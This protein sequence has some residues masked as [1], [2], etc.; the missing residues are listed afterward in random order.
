[1]PQTRCRFELIQ[2]ISAVVK[3]HR[4]Y[5]IASAREAELLVGKRVVIFPSRANKGLELIAR[6]NSDARAYWEFRLV[7]GSFS[8][9]ATPA[10]P[11][12]T[13]NL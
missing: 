4:S 12:I 3:T 8:H 7:K 5:M 10:L 2:N 11:V 13:R 1:M 9:R 6:R